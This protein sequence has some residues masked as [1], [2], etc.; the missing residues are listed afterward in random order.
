M[1]VGFFQ[2]CHHFK[3]CL[4]TYKRLISIV[5]RTDYIINSIAEIPLSVRNGAFLNQYVSQSRHISEINMII[6][7][8][9]NLSNKKVYIGQTIRKMEDR[10]RE[11]ISKVKKGYQLYI[12]RAIRKYGIE[13]FKWE[14]ICVCPS[15]DSLNEREEYYI[16]F[17]NSMNPKYGYN[18]ISGGLNR[19][20]SEIT[21]QKMSEWRTNYYKN[22]PEKRPFKEKNSF[23]NKHH[24]EETK[25]KLH[26]SHLG[27]KHSE[28]SKEKM[29]KATLGFKHTIESRKKMSI[30]QS[31]ENHPMYGI[32]GKNNPNY[33]KHRSEE[34]KKKISNA[35]RGRKGRTH[36]QET[37]DKISKANRGLH[38][39]DSQL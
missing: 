3:C 37:R 13:N 8:I 27:L 36:T 14:V 22:N 39:E 1:I 33:G 17:Y 19:L 6:Y 21:K 25:L 9:T 7:K 29:R 34:T 11:Y 30:A 18:L 23:Y 26:K 20:H 32:R 4:L 5:I 12:Y 16:A 35:L 10:R 38:S 15:I 31:G 24:S 28:K 2:N